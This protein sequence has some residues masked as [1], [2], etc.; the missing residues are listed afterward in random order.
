M[1]PPFKNPKY[2]YIVYFSLLVLLTLIFTL[3]FSHKSTH[4]TWINLLQGLFVSTT[5][6]FWDVFLD[7]LK[8]KALLKIVLSLGLCFTFAFL[9]YLF[10]PELQFDI[11][12]VGIFTLY[13]LFFL[14]YFFKPEI[15]ALFVG[16]KNKELA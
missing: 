14:L 13:F 9:Y 12:I 2:K 16:K 5:L 4:P 3:I 10:K 6:I 7:L 11:R 1:K 8:G 15:K